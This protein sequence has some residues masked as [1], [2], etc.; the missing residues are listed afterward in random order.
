MDIFEAIRNG[1]VKGLDNLG[2]VRLNHNDGA[3]VP[4]DQIPQDEIDHTELENIGTNTHAQIDTHIADTS[5]PHAVTD[6]QVCAG[7][8]G[9]ISFVAYDPT[10]TNLLPHE[11]YI[12]NGRIT[13][14]IL[15]TDEQLS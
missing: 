2:R 1:I 5:N 14:W 12:V 4:I 6:A 7:K 11:V 3:K 15:D 9:H 8:G 13:S 10:G